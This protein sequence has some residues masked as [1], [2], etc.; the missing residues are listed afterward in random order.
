MAV[1]LTEVVELDF[2]VEEL[3][4]DVE[5]ETGTVLEEVVPPIYDWYALVR[6]PVTSCPHISTI[7]IGSDSVSL[8]L[9]SWTHSSCA[10][11]R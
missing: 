2:V 7:T 4:L 1:E 10:V 6:P 8:K 9:H 3:T 11:A 5:V